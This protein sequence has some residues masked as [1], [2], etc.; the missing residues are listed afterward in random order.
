M[1]NPPT[2]VHADENKYAPLMMV[3]DETFKESR[4]NG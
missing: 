4:A 3:I 2:Y 1:S